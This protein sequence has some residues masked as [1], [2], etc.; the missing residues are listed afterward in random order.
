MNLSS[1]PTDANLKEKSPLEIQLLNLL[2]D[3]AMTR[4]EMVKKLGI[5]RTTIYDGLKRLIVRNEVK[6]YPLHNQERARGRPKVLFSL[7]DDE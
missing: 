6:K 3:G 7:I 4:G 1:E 2:S 5:P